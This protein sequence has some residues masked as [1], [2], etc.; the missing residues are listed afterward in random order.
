MVRATDP[1]GT[2]VGVPSCIMVTSFATICLYIYWMRSLGPICPSAA[3][4]D[5][6]ACKPEVWLP[7][8]EE[9]AT[10]AHQQA[11]IRMNPTGTYRGDRSR[12]R[13]IL[14]REGARS[15]VTYRYQK[16]P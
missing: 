3:D 8:N 6:H 12:Y 1:T 13:L 2:L 9:G 16:Y 10:W 4:S 7:D 14:R 15:P 11:R 5:E